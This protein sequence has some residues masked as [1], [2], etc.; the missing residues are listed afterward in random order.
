MGLFGK[1]KK[2]SKK[3]EPEV[4]QDKG[5]SIFDFETADVADLMSSDRKSVRSLCA[6][7]GVNPN[8]LSYFVINDGGRDHYICN[9]YID[10]L[11]P[12]STFG[13]T[14]AKLF[15]FPHTTSKV[16]IRP[17]DKG[18]ATRMLD[19]RINSLDVELYGAEKNGDRNRYRKIELKMQ[20]CEEMS[21]EVE[22]GKTNLFRVGFL[23]SICEDSFDELDS[24]C[25]SFYSLAK[26]S[27]ID[28]SAA[29]SIHAE[30][31]MSN[32]PLADMMKVGVG[33]FKDSVV[34]Y[35]IMD[36][37]G[38]ATM[39][40]HTQANFSHKNGI[41]AG[42][43]LDT[44]RP[45]LLDPYDKS[46]SNYNIIV[47][48]PSGTGKSATIKMW[49]SRFMDVDGYRLAVIDLD[50][51]NG[52]EGE[53]VPL[54]QAY[55][56][57]VYQFRNDTANVLNI[58][59]LDE[60][61]EWNIKLGIEERRLHL[62]EKVNDCVNII[63]SMIKDGREITDFETE[64]FLKEIVTTA[65]REMYAEL[66]IREGEPDSL[67]MQSDFSDGKLVAGLVRKP[68]P[69]LSSLFVKLLLM[70]RNNRSQFHSKAYAVAL[71]ALSI[72][73]RDVIYSE[74]SVA[75]FTPEQYEKMPVDGAGNKFTK[76]NGEDEFVKRVQGSKC[77]FDG[78][79]TF[80]ISPEV[81]A[82]DIDLTQLPDDDRNVAQQVACSFINEKF[83]KKN[84]SN[85]NKLQKCLFIIDEF[86]RMFKYKSAMEFIASM[87]RQARKRF[88]SML[89]ITQ[90]LADYDVCEETR[91]MV[92]NSCM[93][94]LLKQDLMDA[95]FVRETTPL[96][97]AQ[98][99][100]VSQLGGS[101]NFN[102]EVDDSRK[103]ELCLI[104]SNVKVVFMKVDY[105]TSSEAKVCETD[106]AK[107]AKLY[108][109]RAV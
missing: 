18:E 50:S 13:V 97:D 30:A 19:K 71:S 106:P 35:H 80:T 76:V 101:K 41:L 27:G 2:K 64:T 108:G 28:L 54:V 95:T 81:R 21:K 26:E 11:G 100:R 29:Y 85:P 74:K 73:I 90:S 34:K 33:I 56:G 40:N 53:Y 75:I 20:E 43:N 105:L 89:T 6:P 44:F 57:V 94:V 77:Y 47:C 10:K 61:L 32:A 58:F 98:L 51:P 104:D 63:L 3:G 72:Y 55:N 66:G 107:L 62:A 45:I 49:S 102:G 86:H 96:T 103:G 15:N 14:Y 87:Y 83:V 69:A 82:V 92:K 38:V 12:S 67:Y 70:Q 36:K 5:V 46:H 17:L 88:V 31:Y 48:G 7:D 84:S 9:L 16:H 91:A 39:F 68:M 24:A 79:S 23:F 4:T 37:Y 25:R 1:R 59:E 52:Q 78:Q 42:R 65:V 8:P 93:K 109:K 60:E 22:T 99:N